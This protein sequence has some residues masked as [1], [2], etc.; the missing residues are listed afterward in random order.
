M[1]IRGCRQFLL[2]SE[3]PKYQQDPF[4]HLLP[5]WCSPNHP[6]TSSEHSPKPLHLL[7]EDRPWICSAWLICTPGQSMFQAMVK[8][9]YYRVLQMTQFKPIVHFR[10]ISMLLAI[11]CLQKVCHDS[12]EIFR[13]VCS[14]HV[15]PT[16]LNR[17]YETAAIPQIQSF[18]VVR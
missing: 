17:V 18:G 10:P 16:Y 15:G 12:A 6:Q 14:S 3:A 7:A 9:I 4:E 1:A 5:A 13:H 2:P 8:I 11:A